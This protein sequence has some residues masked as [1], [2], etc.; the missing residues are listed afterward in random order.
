MR[1][2]AVLHFFNSVI[3]A[4]VDNLFFFYFCM[5]YIVYQCP[6]NTSTASGIDETVLRTGI[7]S[8]FT[9]YKFRMKYYIALLAFGFQIRQA[10]PS[11]QIFGT[12]NSCRC[13]CRR[14]ISR[15]GRI[16]MALRTEKAVYPTVFMGSETHI[17]NIGCRNNVFGHRYRIVPKT[18]VV[19][20]IRTFG[21]GKE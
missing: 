9:I 7:K 21:Y 3:V 15:R 12:G 6:T 17:I 4:L 10:L 13:R 19:N 1:A 20:A 14:Q 5:R 18:E 2:F 8:V 16:V 11:L